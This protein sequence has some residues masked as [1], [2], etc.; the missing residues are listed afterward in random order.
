MGLPPQVLASLPGGPVSSAAR[1][2]ERSLSGSTGAAT[3]AITHLTLTLDAATVLTLIRKEFHPLRGGPHQHGAEDPAH[4]AYWKRELLAYESGLLPAGPGLRA[5][6]CHAIVDDTVYLEDAGP[7]SPDP[8]EAA[9]QLA[10]WHTSSTLPVVPWLSG[11]QL[12]QRVEVSNLDW[13]A[14]D[15][16]SR[17]EQLWSSRA[18]LL[19]RLA[20]MPH[21]LSHGDFHLGN[22]R[23]DQTGGIVALDW[24]TLG[25]APLGSDLAYLA[26]SA[27]QDLLT[28]YLSGLDG[29]FDRHA[30]DLGY[31]ATLALVGASRVHWMHREGIRVPDGY[32]DFIWANR[33]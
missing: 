8:E 14:V 6:R 17:A 29:R 25:R 9:G 16:D 11:H 15:A 24:G 2:T 33:P 5:P 1:I 22:L 32:V 13:S 12:A 20:G 18:T 27:Q 30:A 21:V 26:L 3:R 19:D 23:L 7:A 4:W 31:R 10:A 28:A